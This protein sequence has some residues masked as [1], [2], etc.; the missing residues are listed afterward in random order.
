MS[1]GMRRGMKA[2]GLGKRRLKAGCSHDWL[3]HNLCRMATGPKVSDIGLKPAPP[4]PLPSSVV[5]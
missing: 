1:R 4:E 5:L 3:P 2:T